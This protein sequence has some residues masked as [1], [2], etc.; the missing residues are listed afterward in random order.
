[1]TK[2]THI[3][4]PLSKYYSKLYGLKQEKRTAFK[5]LWFNLLRSLG[6]FHLRGFDNLGTFAYFCTPTLMEETFAED[7][8]VFSRFFAKFAKVTVDF[9]AES[10]IMNKNNLEWLQI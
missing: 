7:T 5:Q 3:K 10:Q 4:K 6:N 1:M 8:F 2:W 9:I